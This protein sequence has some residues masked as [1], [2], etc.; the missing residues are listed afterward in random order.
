MRNF[1]IAGVLANLAI[2]AS[3]AQSPSNDAAMDDQDYA[4]TY[5]GEIGVGP[6]VLCEY[7]YHR[8]RADFV[9]SGN[10][11]VD[12]ALDGYVESARLLKSDIRK[13]LKPD[14]YDRQYALVK[15]TLD[16]EKIG[17]FDW[18]CNRL[19]YRVSG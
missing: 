19:R 2:S 8:Q 6:A 11:I 9:P 18:S 13:R 12:A 16:G 7:F 15:T 1:W 3:L 17:L 5:A 10:A 4:V 14:A